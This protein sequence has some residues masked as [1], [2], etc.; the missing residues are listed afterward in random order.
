VINR[1]KDGSPY[2]A[3]LTVT[4]L[5]DSDGQLFG[6]V[7]VQRDITHLKELDRL[8]DQF[9]SRIGHELRTPLAN[10]SLYLD[11]LEHGKDEKRP[12]YM[13]VLRN[14]TARLQKLVNGFLEMSELDAEA[15]PLQR[16]PVDINVLIA[17]LVAEH[18]ERAAEHNLQLDT[19]LAP[20]LPPALADTM[21]M[22]RVI[23]I[24]LQNALAYTPDGGR[25]GVMTG[26]QKEEDQEWVTFSVRDTGPG[27]LPE[28]MPHLFERFYRGAVANN[29]T[30][31]GAGLGLSI[32]K[33]V[34][35]RLEGR[36]K[37]ESQPGHGATFSV[38]LKPAYA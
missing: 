34:L 25:I 5:F 19:Q 8:K 14:E 6:L 28:E 15:T 17:Q 33:A 35:D 27:V 36:I 9:V 3:A 30:V 22:R 26:I 2:D 1:R 37:V 12:Q 21:W 4:P 31:P 7:S 23:T 18:S 32:C 24:L 16:A 29:F 38:W 10:V 13:R 20:D 11:L